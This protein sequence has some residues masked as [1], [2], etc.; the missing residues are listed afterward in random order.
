MRNIRLGYALFAAYLVATCV[1]IGWVVAHEPFS[2]DAWNVAVDTGAKPATVSRFFEYWAYEYTHS[3]PRIGQP[4]TYLVYKL[5][6]LCQVLTPLAFVAISAAIATLGLARLPRR[7]RDLALWAVA[8]GCMW[9]ALPEIGRNMFCR[10]YATN[11]VY[12]IAV[13][14]WFLVPLRLGAQRG[15]IAYGLLGVVVGMCN[16]HTGPALVL[17]CALT[18]WWQRRRNEPF[19]L[20][21]A[22]A[23]GVG[24]GFAALF[25]APGQGERYGGIAEQVSLPMRL[26]QRGVVGNLDILREWV[27]YA[28]PLLVIV[29]VLC[30]VAADSERRAR[31]LRW[32][33]VASVLGLVMAMALFVSPKLGSRF[34]MVPMALVLAGVIG[35][36]DVV[37]ERPRQLGALVAVAVIASIYAGARTIPL[38]AKVSTQAAERMHALEATPPGEIFV[39]DAWEQV[40]ESWWFIGDDFRDVQKRDLVAH[41]FNFA[42]V[43]FR[44]YDQKAPL[45]LLGARYVPRYWT[46][47]GETG[48]DATFDLGVAKGFDL[49]GVRRGTLD[50]IRILRARLAPTQVVKFELG[51][52]FTAKPPPMPRDRLLVSRWQDGVLED[53][54]AKIKREGHAT[55]RHL[56]VPKDIA[57]RDIYV[58]RIGDPPRK[59]EP[60]YEY[61][62]W[63]GGVY[64]VL[65]CDATECWVIAATRQG[66]G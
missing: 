29:L 23:I 58:V 57:G 51:V 31:A 54:V 1:H 59:L 4:V 47:D 64:W 39:A 65:A 63:R 8:L 21:L 20:P 45:G 48:V 53:H 3:N 11:Y 52:E 18:A 38:Y 13:V 37:L 7:G 50:S 26:V 56:D 40:D 28:A 5:D 27:V 44:G 30:L 43:F 55:T 2:F 66:G 46:S 32:V 34:Y 41:Y 25:F 42:R 36:A 19:A 9:F 15:A 16:E 62:P 6:Y 14:L 35:V 12:T 10:A 33:G 60:P 61:S 49:D 24:V 17:L 22:G